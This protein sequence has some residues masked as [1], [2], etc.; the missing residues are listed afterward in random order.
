MRGSPPR[1]PRQTARRHNRDMPRQTWSSESRSC[2]AAIQ[3]RFLPPVKTRI[4][5]AVCLTPRRVTCD[6]AYHLQWSFLRLLFRRF[7]SGFVGIFT[8]SVLVLDSLG[9]V[10]VFCTQAQSDSSRTSASNSASI[11]LGVVFIA[12]PFRIF[13]FGRNRR[14]RIRCNCFRCWKSCARSSGWRSSYG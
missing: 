11:C 5:P 7:L 14:R 8:L 10:C 2:P 3:A 13:R 9:S 12:A 1:S 6:H 4:V